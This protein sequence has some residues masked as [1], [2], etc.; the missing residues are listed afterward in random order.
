[1]KM[2]ELGR[3]GETLS[4]AIRRE[5]LVQ[6]LAEHNISLEE[7]IVSSPASR[8]RMIVEGYHLGEP[9][10]H[11]LVTSPRID[12]GLGLMVVKPE[13]YDAAGEVEQ[14]LHS[15]GVKVT[16]TR[17]FIYK[18]EEYWSVYGH[19]FLRNFDVLPH[20]SLL[21]LI[22]ITSPSELITFKHLTAEEYRSFY[23]S[24]GAELPNEIEELGSDPQAV[25][26]CLFVRN[27][28][29]SL[30]KT[31][32]FTTIIEKHIHTMDSE[33]GLDVYW[34]FTGTFRERKPEENIITFNGIHSPN[35]TTELS[36]DKLILL[37][38]KENE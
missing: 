7:F 15:L 18:P 34:D 17:A 31:L 35:N 11:R 6:N 20:C 10:D 14:Y 9:P 19:A 4:D 12:D 21:F 27:G 28:S 16:Q 5:K 33:L 3:H 1:M 29:F 26:D 2:I 30:R 25:F 37:A 23:G 32:V 13:L 22:N 8:L 36:Y 24:L 38:N